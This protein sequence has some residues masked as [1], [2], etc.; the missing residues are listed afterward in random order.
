MKAIAVALP[1]LIAAT[2]G[3]SAQARPF[4]LTAMNGQLTITIG[5]N[6]QVRHQDRHKRK[7]THH[8]GQKQRYEALSPRQ[9]ARILKKRGFYNLRNMRTDGRI[10]SVKARG[11][12]GNLVRLTVSAR[13]G[14]ILN[15]KVLR[16]LRPVDH[17]SY[18][19][20]FDRPRDY[21]AHWDNH[22]NR[23]PFWI[24]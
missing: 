11:A 12:R 14:K 22:R 15:R 19:R 6:D 8:R 9:I 16:R 21:S 5:N 1:L 3:T 20:S 24:R 18:G 2:L 10:Y 23:T 17:R 7:A 13:N 4:D